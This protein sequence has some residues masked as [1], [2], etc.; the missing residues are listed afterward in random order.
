MPADHRPPDI[1]AGMALNR[2]LIIF[3]VTLAP[4]TAGGAVIGELASRHVLGYWWLAVP[5]GCA[6]VPL[7]VLVA[8]LAIARRLA[9]DAAARPGLGDGG[10]GVA[11]D[12]G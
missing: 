7:A 3:A 5:L 2:A 8:G 12:A 1:R 9:R 10:A 11:A 6:A 4:V